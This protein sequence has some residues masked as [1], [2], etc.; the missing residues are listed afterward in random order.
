MTEEV[1]PGIP[2]ETL[3]GGDA[4]GKLVVTK[5]GGFGDE[6]TLARVVAHIDGVRRPGR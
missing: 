1:Q 4:G 6:Q 3:I 5:A 2:M